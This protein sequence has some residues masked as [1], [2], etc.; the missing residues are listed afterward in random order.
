MNDVLN[1]NFDWFSV[2]SGFILNRNA[3]CSIHFN[4]RVR[5]KLT[6]VCNDASGIIK[7][8]Y[9]NAS[10]LNRYTFTTVNAIDFPFSKLYP[11]SFLSGKIHFGVLH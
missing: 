11:T 10:R 3:L 9:K 1:Y 5:G 6:D 7:F 4:G 2:N 8:C